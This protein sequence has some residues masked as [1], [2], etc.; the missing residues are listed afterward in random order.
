MNAVIALF[1]NF[2]MNS[3]SVPFP[4][5]PTLLI[6]RIPIYAH[7]PSFSLSFLVRISNPFICV[8]HSNSDTLFLYLLAPWCRIHFPLSFHSCLLVF[9]FC[10]AVSCLCAFHFGDL[11]SVSQ[12]PV[13]S[14]PSHIPMMRIKATTS[15]RPSNPILVLS[16]FGKFGGV[17]PIL[18]VRRGPRAI[19]PGLQPTF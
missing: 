3:D 5:F 4:F 2:S 14:K 1:S 16:S 6:Y 8:F 15:V 19:Q 17:E 10:V 13:P 18:Y 11:D 9:V 12:L 7:N